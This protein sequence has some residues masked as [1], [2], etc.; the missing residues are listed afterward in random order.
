VENVNESSLVSYAQLSKKVAES[1][2]W[3]GLTLVLL[4]S[5]VKDRSIDS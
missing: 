4:T 3:L 2:S 1:T 5:M